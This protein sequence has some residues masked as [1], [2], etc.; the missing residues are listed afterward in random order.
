M[1][2]ESRAMRTLGGAA[3]ALL[4]YRYWRRTLSQAPGELGLRNASEGV[5]YTYS[6]E[7]PWWLEGQRF[8]FKMLFELLG[9]EGIRE[10]STE[11]YRRI[12]IDDEAPWFR[13]MF[14][15]RASLQQSID[16]Q[17]A[18]FVQMWGG[19]KV[20]T[21]NNKPHC[22]RNFVIDHAGLKFFAMHENVRAKHEITHEGGA[23]WQHHMNNTLL[24]LRP[25][26]VA[27]FGEERARMIE[28][29]IRWFSDHGLENIVQGGPEKAVWHP[30]RIVFRFLMTLTLKFVVR[31]LYYPPK[32]KQ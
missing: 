22:L 31:D 29:T 17:A 25:A 7:H 24:T 13:D 28:K 1:A 9:E 5:G 8:D 3:V 21:A 19:P 18:F 23:R 11:F 30:A 20:Y 2:L 15:R 6:K 4:A 14:T 26:W 16:R 10:I 12:Y 27:K 32:S